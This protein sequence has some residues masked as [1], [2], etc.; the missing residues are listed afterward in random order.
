[1]KNI[2]CK[3]TRVFALSIFC[4]GC[5]DELNVIPGEKD[6]Q[7]VANC[8]FADAEP[9][10]VYISTSFSPYHDVKSEII[11]DAVVEIF[12]NDRSMGFLTYEKLY[13][14]IIFDTTMIA[15]DSCFT[16]STIIPKT[17][18]NY[19]IEIEVPGY[20]KI[21]ASSRIPSSIATQPIVSY[22]TWEDRSGYPYSFTT[23]QLGFKDPPES[24]YY[25]ISSK[26]YDP[27]P[28]H[29]HQFYIPVPFGSNDP[30]IE[31]S[32]IKD[33]VNTLMYSFSDWRFNG[34]DYIFEFMIGNVSF[35]DTLDIFISLN[36]VSREF[37]YYIKSI[38]ASEISKDN[39][40]ADPLPIYTN[41]DNGLG[42]FA[43][44]SQNVQKITLT[45]PPP[46]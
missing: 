14:N 36:N 4:Y 35:Y 29:S 39:F 42:I 40:L 3:I 12:E 10:K 28:G 45:K 25:H 18:N 41:I 7:I 16:N 26:I 31:E 9:F 24:N 27:S 32:N 30:V 22:I 23:Y 17:Q 5:V 15:I 19:R 33:N 8:L 6:P 43:G 21:T 44:Y 20:K 34:S 1:M 2:F 11:T 13:G 37:E 38:M 46:I